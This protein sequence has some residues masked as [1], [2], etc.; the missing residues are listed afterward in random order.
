[1]ASAKGDRKP[2][3]R[4]GCFGTM[5]FSESARVSPVGSVG[6]SVP[7]TVVRDEPGWLCD[8]DTTHFQRG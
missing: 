1:M 7:S 6:A 5:Q 4:V 8:V 2:C 3:T